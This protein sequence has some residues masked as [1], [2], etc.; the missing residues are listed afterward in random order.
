MSMTVT[1]WIGPAILRY[2]AQ[3]RRTGT[4]WVKSHDPAQV[5]KVREIP[6]ADRVDISLVRGER[7]TLVYVLTHPTRLPVR[8]IS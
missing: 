8:V 5:I 1:D 6:C 2:H 4:E 7:L 3:H